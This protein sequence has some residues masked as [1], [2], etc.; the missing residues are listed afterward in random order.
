MKLVTKDSEIKLVEFLNS[1]A[2]DLASW[3]SVHLRF[4]ELL[5]HHRNDYQTKIA[6]N[7]VQDYV[8]DGEGSIFILKDR[9]IVLLCKGIT[10]SQLEKMIFR[11]RYLYTDDPLAYDTEG[12]ENPNFSSIHDLSLGDD[13]LVEIAR[14]K[15]NAAANTNPAVPAKTVTKPGEE[16]I[17]PLTPSR[18]SSIESDILAADLSRVMRRQP[19]CALVPGKPVRRVFDEF[20]INIPHLRKLIMSNVDLTA[21]RNLFAYLTQILDGKMLDM[22]RKQPAAYF[23]TPLSLNLNVSSLLSDKFSAFDAAM[24]PQLRVSVVI[25]IQV[26]DVFADMQGFIFA[27]EM[28]QKKG[29]RVCL[30][31]LT[32]L[33]FTQLDRAALGFDLAK[34]QWNSAIK[35]G[36]PKEE[37]ERILRTAVERCGP[38]RLIL[39]RC[40]TREAVEHGQSMGISLFQGRYLDTL[41][42]P[43]SK[44]VN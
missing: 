11:L 26:S 33:S 44:V 31:G 23:D 20:Y 2:G 18:L 5:E 37:R 13:A 19:I 1:I 41:I 27:K 30:D 3:R 35:T 32:D 29:Y 28:V 21:N 38:T 15:K 6:I 10:K 7:V 16:D 24:K 4:S 17:R 14:R 8:K 42:N 22:L 43:D 34:L 12:S 9:D 39:C 36:M 25:E 40:D